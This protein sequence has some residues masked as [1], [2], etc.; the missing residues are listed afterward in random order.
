V[1][2]KPRGRRYR[3]LTARGDSIYVQIRSGGR[4]FR[5]ST[6]V[7][8]W[9]VAAAMR[10]TYMQRK[11]IGRGV[12]FAAPE[13]PRLSDFASRYLIEDLGHLAPT[14][15]SDRASYLR[16][17]GPL[18]AGL[19][20]RKLDEIDP[21]ALRVWWTE[22]VG[23]GKG[24]STRTGRAYLDVLSSVFGYAEDLGLIEGG[25]NPVPEFRKQLHR[26]TK[27]KSARAESEAGRNIRPIEGRDELARLVAAAAAEADDDYA[28]THEVQR[29]EST[30]RVRSLEERTGGLRALAAVLLAL[31]AGL[32]LGE[33]CGLTWGQVRWGVGE[34]DPSRALRIDRSRARGGELGPPKSGRSRTVIMSRRLRRVLT[35][36]RRA[37]FEP[38]PEAPVL[39]YFDPQ[40]FAHRAWRRILERAELGHRA[41]KDLRDTFASQLLSAGIQLAYVSKQLGHSDIAITAKHYGKWCGGDVYAEPARLL[42]GEEP[43]D[44]LAR[45]A[46]GDPT[47]DPTA[48]GH[49]RA[50]YA[51]P[52]AAAREVLAIPQLA[53]R[54]AA[55]GMVELAGIEPAT[56]RLPA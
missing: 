11:G 56:L 18:I 8:D 23:E 17:S 16:K 7:S 50:C 1:K 22:Y 46:A 43:A 28:R 39:P 33:V 38:G 51:S 5:F 52:T 32:R 2:A 54:R 4:R 41:P 31:D 27:T 35:A 29:G 40:N 49:A 26:R 13:A 44:L 20:A 48:S 53:P 30:K 3:N 6:G 55:G 42:P 21:A 34:S 15:R 37:Q 12:L 45:L 9:D 36:L 10:D 24:R 14:T 47:G 25:T 19:G